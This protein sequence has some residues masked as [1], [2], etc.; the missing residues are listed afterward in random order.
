[1]TLP[2]FNPYSLEVSGVLFLACLQLLLC[3]KFCI[4][5]CCCKFGISGFFPRSNNVHVLIITSMSAKGQAIAGRAASYISFK[6]KANKEDYFLDVSYRIVMSKA[7]I[8]QIRHFSG[9]T[10]GTGMEAIHLR[11][12][13]GIDCIWS[14]P[15]LSIPADLGTAYSGS[16][17]DHNSVCIA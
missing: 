9:W 17:I 13:F 2:T 15:A 10:P 14:C 1:M 6:E 4:H 11:L 7:I 3:F 16:V 5:P 12:E 8:L